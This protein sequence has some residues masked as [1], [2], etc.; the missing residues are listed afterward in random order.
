VGREPVVVNAGSRGGKCGPR[1]LGAGC[2]VGE[3]M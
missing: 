3:I 1:F 2:G